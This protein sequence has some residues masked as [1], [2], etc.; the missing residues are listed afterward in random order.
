MRFGS[1][2]CIIGDR[3]I[4]SG[5]IR[6][7]FVELL[8]FND[9][10]GHMECNTKILVPG[11]EIYAHGSANIDDK[12]TILT[13]GSIGNTKSVNVYEGSLSSN[14][15]NVN[16]KQLPSL[17]PGRNNHTSFKFKQKVFVVGGSTDYGRAKSCD[18]YNLET[19]K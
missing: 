6:H 4:I 12:T 7:K 1:K 17:I 13:G 3:I 18:T 19:E 5:G 15:D 16:W 2:G 10:S 14:G 9:F 8:T 11:N